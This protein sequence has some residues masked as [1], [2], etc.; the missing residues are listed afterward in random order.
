MEGNSPFVGITAPLTTV[1]LEGNGNG[2]M[3]Q[4]FTL[5]PTTPPPPPLK[6]TKTEGSFSQPPGSRTSSSWL[7]VPP[8]QNDRAPY[9]W[10][11]NPLTIFCLKLDKDNTGLMDIT[12]SSGVQD[13]LFQMPQTMAHENYPSKKRFRCPLNG[14]GNQRPVSEGS[15]KRDPATG[16][17][18]DIN[19]VSS[20]KRKWRFPT[21]YQFLGSN[22]FSWERSPLK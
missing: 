12:D 9:Q 2:D 17:R 22:L 21:R 7:S 14:T 8:S 3:A 15:C 4:S 16:R 19:L 10:I 6:R 13:P 5:I 20:T 1:R 18:V 11:S